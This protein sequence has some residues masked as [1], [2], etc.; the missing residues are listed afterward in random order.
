MYKSL[1]KKIHVKGCKTDSKE[2]DQPTG[3]AEIYEGL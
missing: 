3:F 2:S 1:G